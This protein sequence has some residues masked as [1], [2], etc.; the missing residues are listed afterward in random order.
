MQLSIENHTYSETIDLVQP[1]SV[2]ARESAT[3]PIYEPKTS[4][5]QDLT[6]RH[7]SSLIPSCV[8]ESFK[9]TA[10]CH[11]TTLFAAAS[12]VGSSASPTPRLHIA[13]FDEY[14]ANVVSSRNE[15]RH[16]YAYRG[17]GLPRGRHRREVFREAASSRLRQ[18]GRAR[19]LRRQGVRHQRGTRPMNA[20]DTLEIGIDAIEIC[21]RAASRRAASR[22]SSS[23]VV[24][25]PAFFHRRER[26]IHRIERQPRARS[27][28]PPR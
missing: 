4:N 10:E 14:L 27:R 25:T 2:L 19:P 23:V 11:A 16:R 17:H 13:P 24:V 5:G 21:A 26:R 8:N 22:A 6:G 15:R 3:S 20:S 18:V 12:L 7:T 9:F 28:H 1:R